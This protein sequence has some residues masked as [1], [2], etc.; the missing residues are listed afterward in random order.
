MLFRLVGRPGKTIGQGEKKSRYD[1][2]QMNT[3]IPTEIAIR[4]VLHTHE[5]AQQLDRRNRHDRR[6]E[7]QFQPGEIDFA[8][9]L[10]PIPM[11]GLSDPRD[12]ILIARTNHQHDERS[13]QSEIDEAEHR[14]ND[15]RFAGVDGVRDGFG[16]SPNSFHRQNREAQRQGNVEGNEKPPAG[17]ENFF[18]RAFQQGSMPHMRTGRHMVNPSAARAG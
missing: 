1:E 17:E 7:F 15:R 11:F 4:R 13:R 6:H 8:H 18:E 2:D 3:H 9:P 16:E 12:E 5:G 10:G 14:E